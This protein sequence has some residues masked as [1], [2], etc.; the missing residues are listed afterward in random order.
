MSRRRVDPTVGC[1]RMLLNPD[2]IERYR[3][4]LEAWDEPESYLYMAGLITGMAELAAADHDQVCRDWCPTC[5][6]FQQVLAV[7]SAMELQAGPLVFGAPR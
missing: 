4:V 7:K 5:A 1:M 6:F 3:E 2:L